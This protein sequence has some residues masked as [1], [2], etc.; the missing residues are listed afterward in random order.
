MLSN[1]INNNSKIGKK[2]IYLMADIIGI[3]FISFKS[4]YKSLTHKC[5]IRGEIRVSSCCS[6]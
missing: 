2:T 3:T 1:T 6:K 5:K 4:V